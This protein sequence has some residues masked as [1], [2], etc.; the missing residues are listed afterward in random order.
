MVSRR[1]PGTTKASRRSRP[2]RRRAV[3][4]PRRPFREALEGVARFLKAT[5]RPS[6]II[7]GVAVIARGF[8]RSTI[9]IDATVAASIEEVGELIKIGAKQG[10]T[11]RINNAEPFARENLVLLLEHRATGVP[12]DVSLAQQAFERS[13]AIHA[14]EVSFEGVVIPVPSLTALLI[15]KLVAGR[16]QDLRDVEALLKTGTQFDSQAISKTLKEFDEILETSRA[17]EFRRLLKAR[18]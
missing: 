9:D 18:R 6:V 1:K 13:A 2:A 7:G 10:L 5:G 16:P 3:E 11:P 4:A 17:E 15:Y 12:V 14:E 8:A